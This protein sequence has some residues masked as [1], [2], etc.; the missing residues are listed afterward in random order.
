M[1]H[2]SPT[3]VGSMIQCTW[4]CREGLITSISVMI[5]SRYAI[6]CLLTQPQH[7][8]VWGKMYHLSLSLHQY[9]SSEHLHTGFIINSLVI[10]ISLPSHLA[11]KNSQNYL[12]FSCIIINP[13]C[14]PLDWFKHPLWLHNPVNTATLHLKLDQE[15]KCWPYEIQSNAQIQSA[16]Q[17]VDNDWEERD[18]IEID[19]RRIIQKLQK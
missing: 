11:S 1:R 17:I 12:G 19:S 18:I 13:I 8:S 7:C 4:V 6:I 5:S 16:L 3:L 2:W 15:R 14:S 10:W 9:C